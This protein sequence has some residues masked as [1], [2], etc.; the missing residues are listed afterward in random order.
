MATAPIKK[1]RRS[2]ICSGWRAAMLASVLDHQQGRT[3]S[4]HP[5]GRS[6]RER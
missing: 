1:R 4:H 3:S 6:I 5:I 2:T